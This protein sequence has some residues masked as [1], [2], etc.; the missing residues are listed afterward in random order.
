MPPISSEKDVANAGG[1][2]GLLMPAVAAAASFAPRGDGG[3]MSATPAA[4][5]RATNS[6]G[7]MLRLPLLIVSMKLAA[8]YCAPRGMSVKTLLKPTT[9]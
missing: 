5:M 6:S 8:E 9:H 1:E 2:A 4:T 7:S 3:G